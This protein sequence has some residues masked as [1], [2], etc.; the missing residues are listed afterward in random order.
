[1]SE[2]KAVLEA[3][4]D[5]DPTRAELATLDLLTKAVHGLDQISRVPNPPGR[6]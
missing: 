5:Q 4:R 6:P 2:L 1:M 3:I